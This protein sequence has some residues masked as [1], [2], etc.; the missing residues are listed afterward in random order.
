MKASHTWLISIADIEDDLP[1]S[2]IKLAYLPKLGQVRLRLSAY[3]EDE[4]LLKEKVNEYAAR[5]IERVSN[6]VMAEED[7]PLRKSYNG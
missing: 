2:H 6:V 3:G 4:A 1:M 7:I 5:I